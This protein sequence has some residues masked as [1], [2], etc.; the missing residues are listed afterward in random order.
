MFFCNG[1]ISFNTLFICK[2]NTKHYYSYSQRADSGRYTNPGSFSA[3]HTDVIRGSRRFDIDYITDSTTLSPIS[4]DGTSY[5]NYYPPLP[6]PESSIC[7]EEEDNLE[8]EADY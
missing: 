1:K 8:N 4:R 6:S 2:R 5:N 7:S 3:L